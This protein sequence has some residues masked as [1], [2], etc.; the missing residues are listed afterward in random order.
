MSFFI[1]MLSIGIQPAGAITY[2]GGN[3]LVR[4]M[5][6]N[7][8]YQGDLWM[9][10]NFSYTQSDGAFTYKNGTG[11]FNLLYGVRH[12][13]EVGINQTFYQDRSII[14]P[15]PAA[16]PLRISIKGALP[17]SAPSAINLA[18][19]LLISV[20]VGS[21]TNVEQESYVSPRTA[22]GGMVIASFDSNPV[23]LRRSKRIHIN[24]GYLFHNDKAAFGGG[25]NTSQML[26]GLGFQVPVGSFMTFFTELTGERF[27]KVNPTVIV[28]REANDT[29]PDYFRVTPGFRQ[30]LRRVIF[31]AG[32][33]FRP[34][35]VGTYNDGL[36]N[37]PVYPRWKVFMSLQFRLMEGVPPTYRRGRS[38][39]ISGRSYYQYGRRGTTDARGIGPGV[40]QNLEERQ[41][42]LDQVEKDLQEI[43]E[44]RIKAQRELEELKKSL[45]NQSP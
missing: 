22:V 2:Y 15:G 42:L 29:A 24:L 16:G 34:N 17:T 6:A 18:G 26:L 32:V 45:E 4:L 8:V 41:E 9:S 35:N 27:V 3:G 40:I 1:L 13:V 14:G 11:S 31:Q 33:D 21:A 12:Y 43:R 19:Q 44:Q 5:T 25:I 38:M 28:A 23:D 39:R 7:N 10:G 30:Q 37:Q 36:D 20:P